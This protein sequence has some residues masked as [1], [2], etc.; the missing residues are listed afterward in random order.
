MSV[1]PITKPYRIASG[2][3]LAD[4][5]W[6]HGRITVKAGG[7][8][9]GQAFA[10]VETDDPLGA[11]VPRHVHHN[12]DETFYV[13]EGELTALV[14]DERIDLSAGD[15]LFAPRGVPHTYVVRSEH[16]RMLATI[17]PGGARAGL[18]QSGC[19]R[20]GRRASD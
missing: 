20:H 1:E 18:R 7:D 4:V 17:S 15:Y 14:G 5:W 10:Q 2:K 3:G 16:A 19:S 8:E 9:T 13:I 11:G 12:E 6:K